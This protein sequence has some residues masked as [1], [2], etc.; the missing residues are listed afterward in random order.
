MAF[1]SSTV[2]G[3]AAAATLLL[4]EQYNS[5][6]V[7]DFIVSKFVLPSIR[8][9]RI[10]RFHAGHRKYYQRKSWSAFVE[11]LTERQFRRYFRM[12]KELFTILCRQIEGCIGSAQFKGEEYLEGIMNPQHRDQV[13]HRNNILFA[14]AHTTGGIISGEVKLA[15]TLRILGGGSYLDLA[16]LFESSFNHTHKIVKHVVKNWLT[17][18]SFYPINGIAYCQDDEKMEEVALQFSRASRGVINGCIGAL[19]GWVVKIKK[20]SARDGVENPQ[21]F[22]SRKGYYGINVQVIVDKRKRVLFR[23][24]MSR[25]AEH[26]STAFKSCGLYKWLT[27]NWRKLADKSL[28]FIADSAYSIKS[29]LLTP[30]DNAAHGT[31]EDNY[32]FFHSSSRISVECCFGEVDLR[33][34]IFWRPL[35]FSLKTNS[36]IIDACL[37]L[38]NFIIENSNVNFMDSIDK[39]VFDEECRRFFSIHPD[40]AE[41]VDGGDMNDSRPG[42]PTRQE[43]NAASVGRDWRDLIRDDIARQGLSRPRTNWYRENNRLFHT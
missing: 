9:G 4:L 2:V 16:L 28:Y 36:Q 41:G 24:I 5:S 12:S 22:Y 42:R 31:A 7:E 8:L 15:V 43:A 20:P 26:D 19:D 17:H 13:H 33:F 23:S 34:G 29:F 32:N 39:E 11:R 37:R 40:I 30:Y 3:A 14:H 35:K 38:H 6:Y 10:N 1:E 21:S 27:L 18:E 25:G